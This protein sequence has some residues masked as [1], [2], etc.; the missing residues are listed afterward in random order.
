MTITADEL[1]KNYLTYQLVLT[2]VI[3]TEKHV[4]SMPPSLIKSIN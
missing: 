2:H 1:E 4:K 3:S